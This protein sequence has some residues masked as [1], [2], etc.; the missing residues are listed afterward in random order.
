[1]PDDFKEPLL[2]AWFVW[3]DKVDVDLDETEHEAPPLAPEM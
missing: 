1:M 2:V 3:R